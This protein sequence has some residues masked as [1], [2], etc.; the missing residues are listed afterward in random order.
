MALQYDNHI[1]D[2]HYGAIF[3]YCF[4]DSPREAEQMAEPY[5]LR[6]RS[7][8]PMRDMN[9]FGPPEVLSALLDKY[10]EAGATKFALRPACPPEMTHEQMEMLGNH[11]IPRYHKS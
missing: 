3:S 11:I 4:A 2:D 9:A 5:N 1:E 7:D 6:R 8:V 10:I